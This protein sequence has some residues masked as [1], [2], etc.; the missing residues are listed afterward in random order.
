[1]VDHPA[2]KALTGYL[3]VRGDVPRI[4]YARAIE[5][6]TGAQLMKMF[7]TPRIATDKISE[8]RPHIERGDHKRIY[9][10]SPDGYQEIAAVFNGKHPET[11]D[12]L[13]VVDGPPDGALPNDL[14]PQPKAFVPDFHRGDRR[15][16]GTPTDRRGPAEG[17]DRRSQRPATGPTV[18]DKVKDAL[19]VTQR[20]RASS[21]NDSCSRSISTRTLIRSRAP[22]ST[23][24]N[25]TSLRSGESTAGNGP[26]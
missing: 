13:E 19:G 6:L 18:V 12:E 15:D 23:L 14:P 5:N 3:L 25:P 24:A 7:P 22:S 16:R 4:A 17:A 1:M 9:H 10:F 20:S 21:Q 2:A 26:A 8:C 11:G